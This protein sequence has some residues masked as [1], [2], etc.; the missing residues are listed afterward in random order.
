MKEAGIIVIGAGAAGLM[1]AC[2]AASCGEDVV[3]L[4]KMPRPGR[5]IMIT[6]K[7]RC[8]FTN[9]KEWNDFQEHV[10]PKANFLRPSFQNLTPE[11]LI[12]FFEENGMASVVERGDRA[13]PS[14]HLA[15]DV[16]DTL[17][18]AT[19]HAGAK[20]ICDCT[21]TNVID[22]SQKEGFIVNCG[23]GS[24]WH[25]R[26]LI[27]T[28]G[29]LSYP[30]TG[31]TGD[32][33][34]WAEAFGHKLTPR[35]PS[36]TAITPK[37]YRFTEWISLKNVALSTIIDGNLSQEEFGDL[38]FTNGGIEG[39][40]GFKVSRKCVKALLN[41][42]KVQAVIDLKPAVDDEDLDKRIQKL[43]DEVCKDKR[44]DGK[45]Y[46][47]RFGVLLGKVLPMEV[48]PMFMA[49]NPELDHKRLAKALK[50]WR[51]D[52]VGNV[53]Y[54]RCVIT[55]G[56]VSLDEV[57]Q[58]TLESKKRKGLHLAG[59][60]LDLDADTGGYNLHI[61]FSTG[62]LAGLSAARS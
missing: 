17:V 52:I 51:M 15:S 40:I 33:Y 49:A 27:L 31:S 16:V 35:F 23:D 56:G 1:A 14:S 54:E 10:H 37:D 3:V 8:N 2:G 61:A 50:N 34:G 21:V 25:C 48:I 5:K 28:T 55:A 42:S 57:N 43:W 53:G 12:A 39:P 19:S 29:G 7:G 24:S 58:K 4:E 11:K 30:K 45:P 20:V 44:S 26:K 9:V 18:Y 6:G 59:E 13:F 60:V 46:K 47:T 62:Y 32:G 38:D 22:D 36:L 41:G